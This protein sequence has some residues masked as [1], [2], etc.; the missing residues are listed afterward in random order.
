MSMLDLAV[1][2]DPGN[3]TRGFWEYGSGYTIVPNRHIGLDIGTQGQAKRVPALL[4]GPIVSWVDTGNLGRIYIQDVRESGS[5]FNYLS[6]CHM[7]RYNPPQLGISLHQGEEFGRLATGPKSLGYGHPNF[8]GTSW[9]GPHLHLVWH[10]KARGAYTLNQNDRYGNPE[11]LI[12]NILSTPAD[13]G[14]YTPFEPIEEDDMYTDEDRARDIKTANRVD[15][16]Y[17]A[18]FGARN[19]TGKADPLSWINIDGSAQQTNYGVLPLVLHN[20][21]LIAETVA[22]VRDLSNRK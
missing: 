22:K 7:S 17:A 18:L 5:E 6:Y 8:P 13:S 11:D 9:N 2:Y 4:P 15:A 21:T 20:Q 12:R 1:F 19:V 10:N 16:I 3:W 14:G